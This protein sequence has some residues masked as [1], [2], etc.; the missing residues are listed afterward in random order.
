VVFA[1]RREAL[2]FRRGGRPRRL[3]GAPCRAALHGDGPG[4]V[5]VVETG[6]GIAAAGKAV[7]WLLAQ[8]PGEAGTAPQGGMLSRAAQSPTVHSGTEWAAKAWHPP[9]PTRVLLAG[10]SG[11]LRP[12]LGVGDLLWADAVCDADGGEQPTTWP[13]GPPSLPRGRLLTVRS[14]VG[15][16]S[17]KRRLGERHRADAVDMEAAAVARCCARAGVPFGCLR[18]IS[19]NVDTAL[20][21]A[22]LD[23]LRGGRVGPLRL[24]GA[25]LRRPRLV[26][27]LWRLGADTRRAA[28]VLGKALSELL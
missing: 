4:A 21:P 26:G 5:L 3:A 23:V 20:S 24:M 16:P 12:G 17:E 10:F 28:R 19:D 2:Y 14:L 8:S 13:A 27:E 1:L 9:K 18:V 6:V 11:A 22:L 7:D 25:V 15:D